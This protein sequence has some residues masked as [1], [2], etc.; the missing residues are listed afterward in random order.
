MTEQQIR[1]RLA[2]LHQEKLELIKALEKFQKPRKVAERKG[3]SFLRMA[4][5]M[6]E[7]KWEPCE[8]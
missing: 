2:E 8:E 5:R 3:S 6:V 1:A 7:S 4:E